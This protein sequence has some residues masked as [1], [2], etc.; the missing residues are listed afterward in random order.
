[1]IG[2]RYALSTV[3]ENRSNSRY[4]AT[5]S[6]EQ[7]T[8]S[9]G[10]R[11][12]AAS[13]T[14]R[15]CAGFRYACSKHTAI[16]SAPAAITASSARSTLAG[17]S[18]VRTVPSAARRSR[19]SKRCLRSTTGLGRT[20][21]GTKSAGIFRLVRPI[22]IRS[23]K[24]A[25]VRIATR[26][27]RRSST[28]LV[29]TVV[30]CT[31]RRTSR[32][33]IPSARSPERTAE[34]SLCGVDGTLVTTTLPVVSSAAVRSVNVPPTSIPTMNMR[35]APTRVFR[36]SVR[37]PW[38]QIV[39]DRAASCGLASLRDYSIS[40]TSAT[41]SLRHF[42]DSPFSGLHRQH[43]EEDEPQHPEHQGHADEQE[44]PPRHA[45]SGRHRTRFGRLNHRRRDGRV[46]VLDIGEDALDLLLGLARALF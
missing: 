27:P 26:A 19:T 29:P 21:V 18:G 5:T 30:P 3:V 32:P 1:M 40:E 44:W 13:A 12:F 28:A 23:R 7:D 31:S 4:S 25:V 14:A 8:G 38:R 9:F 6:A 20:K 39:A 42:L 11:P 45:R 2:C 34:L 37:V 35:E 33:A 43:S 10:Y 17:S 41:D 15:S 16:A 22:S 46:A 24:P 36:G